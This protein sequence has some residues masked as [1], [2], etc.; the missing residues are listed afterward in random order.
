MT[1]PF[2]YDVDPERFRLASRVTRQHLLAE[3]SLYERLAEL[4]AEIGA[5]RVL[6]VGCGEGALISARKEAP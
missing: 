4:L 6:D 2:D 1:T 3:R 5:R